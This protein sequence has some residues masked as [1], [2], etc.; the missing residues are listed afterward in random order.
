MCE[1]KFFKCLQEAQ[2]TSSPNGLSSVKV[3]TN[4]RSLCYSLDLGK[5]YE[6]G[7]LW[8]FESVS[9]HGRL[10]TGE[11]R[12]DLE[13]RNKLTD[14]EVR[15]YTELHRNMWADCIKSH[16]EARQKY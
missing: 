2:N 1:I 8:I 15:C 7:I 14:V 5:A 13:Q 3:G 6:Y 9:L 10:D 4:A 16:V 11:V 12:H